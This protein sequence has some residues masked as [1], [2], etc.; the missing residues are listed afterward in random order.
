MGLRWRLG[1]P[2]TA[3]DPPSGETALPPAALERGSQ[4]ALEPPV[5]KSLPREMPGAHADVNASIRE[6]HTKTPTH[7]TTFR[8]NCLY[9]SKRVDHS[10]LADAVS[11]D[12]F[13]GFQENQRASIWRSERAGGVSAHHFVQTGIEQFCVPCGMRSCARGPQVNCLAPEYEDKVYPRVAAIGTTCTS[14]PTV[15]A[16]DYASPLAPAW[17][18]CRAIH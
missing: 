10:R 3:T 17:L 11:L 12:I 5:R 6:W 2:A 13:S 18:I 7:F 14:R 15:T 8:I 1:P 4:R 9:E 16:P